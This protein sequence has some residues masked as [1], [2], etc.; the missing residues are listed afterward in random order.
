MEIPTKAPL[1]DQGRPKV[2][3]IYANDWI[4]RDE[5]D[6]VQAA[7]RPTEYMLAQ[8]KAGGEA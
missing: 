6:A 7:L 3:D 1:D 2:W 8:R 5:W 4:T